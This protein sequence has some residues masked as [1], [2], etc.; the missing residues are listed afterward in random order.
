MARPVTLSAPSWRTGRVPTTRYWVVD[1]TMFDGL[2]RSAVLATLRL[3]HAPRGVLDGADDLVVAGAPAQVPREPEADAL[4]AR[5]RFLVEQRLGRDEEAG[6]ADAALERRVLEERLLEW[7]HLPRLGQPLDRRDLG[8]LRL[9]AEHEARVDET[10]V[11]DD[12]AGAT[13]AVVAP[14]LRAGQP[15]H[16]AQALEQALARL[17]QEV[18]GLAVDGRRDVHAR[19]VSGRGHRGPPPRGLA[20][21]RP[22]ARGG[23]A[24]RPGACAGRRCRACRRWAW[25]RSWR[26][27]RRPPATPR[28]PACLRA[29]G[30]PRAR[31]A[32]SAPPRRARSAPT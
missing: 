27:R 23:S 19:G 22:P 26:S 30:Q 17:A 31:R 4:L 18:G 25:R 28:P 15:D 6:G 5:V 9:D 13:V 32:A 16:V 29:P 20:R 1:R 14:L 3:L 10:A 7:V 8:P 11:Q 21:S 12:R 24:R 2:R